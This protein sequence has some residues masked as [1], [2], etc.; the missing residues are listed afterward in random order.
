M[1]SGKKCD[2]FER[3]FFE[4]VAHLTPRAASLR[5]LDLHGLGMNWGY[6][7]D[8]YVKEL[9]PFYH[10]EEIDLSSNYIDTM[11]IDL[12]RFKHLKR[13]NLS[14]N[15]LWYWGAYGQLDL[16]KELPVPT[17]EHL[18]LSFCEIGHVRLRGTKFKA[19]LRSL[20]LSGNTFQFTKSDGRLHPVLQLDAFPA[21]RSLQ[22]RSNALKHV[23]KLCFLPALEQLD[24]SDNPACSG[25]EELLRLPRLRELKLSVT[26]LRRVPPALLKLQQL[27]KLDVRGSRLDTSALATLRRGLPTTEI[28]D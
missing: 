10:V 25:Y 3:Q 8:L 24:L 26:G 20:D 27:R 4:R 28:I 9:S 2:D 16:A 17:L 7:C 5:R 19:T 15:A 13:L 6:A 18:D 23:P 1:S 14:N 21:L 11:V 22:L 12:A